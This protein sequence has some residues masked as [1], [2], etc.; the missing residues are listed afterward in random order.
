MEDLHN[1]CWEIRSILKSIL[2]KINNHPTQMINSRIMEF[3]IPHKSM[4]KE[5]CHVVNFHKF[6]LP[7]TNSERVFAEGRNIRENDKVF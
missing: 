6:S 2:K 7:S 4:K 1:I 5:E 3:I